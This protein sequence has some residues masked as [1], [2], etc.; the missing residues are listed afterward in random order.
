MPEVMV[1]TRGQPGC[2]HGCLA[3]Y[4]QLDEIA[5]LAGHLIA[6]VGPAGDRPAHVP[7]GRMR[8]FPVLH[9]ECRLR[10]GVVIACMIVRQT[11]QDHVSHR[12]RIDA[13]RREEI[14]RI[15]KPRSNR[16]WSGR[17]SSLL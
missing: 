9:M 17:S 11:G 1:Y 4:W 13:D 8:H 3:R 5:D 2:L 12:R 14:D 15:G 16:A 7:P 6:F 10:E